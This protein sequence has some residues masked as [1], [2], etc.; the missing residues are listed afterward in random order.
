MQVP[1]VIHERLGGPDVKCNL[2][3]S[4]LPKEWKK[5]D[6]NSEPQSDVMCNGTLCLENTWVRNSCATCRV[7]TVLWEGMNIA[8]FI[9]Q[10]TTTRIAEKS[11]EAGSCLMKSIKI[12][13]HGWE[14]IVGSCFNFP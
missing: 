9:K 12:D 10:S 3:Q 7:F 11:L 8:C 5:C 4:S 2:I 6:M 14:G 13:D 1:V